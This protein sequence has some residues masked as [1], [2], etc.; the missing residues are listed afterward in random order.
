MN[1]ILELTSL[2][3]WLM[4]LSATALILHDIGVGM[5]PAPRPK[6]PAVASKGKREEEDELERLERKISRALQRP[7]SFRALQRE[8]E[9]SITELALAANGKAMSR[10]PE[11]RPELSHEVLRDSELARFVEDHS[12]AADSK[13]PSLTRNKTIAEL[14][15]T[16]M[17]L[18]RAEAELK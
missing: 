6:P 11:S 2:L 13:A 4:L 17:V 12:S 10:I 18:E 9:Q 15:R 5:L 1:V 8:V 16:I 7:S 3:W 14:N